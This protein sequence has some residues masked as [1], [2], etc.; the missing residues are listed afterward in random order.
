MKKVI[1]SKE[2]LN[3]AK[4]RNTSIE[5]FNKKIATMRKR[6][7][8]TALHTA[9]TVR[10]ELIQ[11]IKNWINMLEKRIFDPTIIQEMDLNKVI[12]L[13]KFV[14]QYSLKMLA[15]INDMEELF[16]KYTETMQVMDNLDKKPS[17]SLSSDEVTEMKKN[18]M[19]AFID[20]LKTKSE[21]IEP[22]KPKV[23][24]GETIPDHVVSPEI[25]D[26]EIP[27]GVDPVF[28]SELTENDFP[29]QEIPL[30]PD[31]QE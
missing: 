2:L 9:T 6:Q 23:P 10:V 28:P 26:A 27:I 19:K 11:K 20:N 3:T 13:F 24:L 14:S 16:K 21:T 18:L 15:Q 7:L 29:E 22:P 5:L 31:K 12:G 30:P 17:A 25:V 8:L 4:D 1:V